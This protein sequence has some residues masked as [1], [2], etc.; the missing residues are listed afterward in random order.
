M[1]E[2]QMEAADKFALARDLKALGYTPLYAKEIASKK[3]GLK[4]FS[5]GSV[6]SGKV[7]LHEKI[8]FAK[9]LSGM[10]SAGLPLSRALAVL[11]KQ[12]TNKAF[13]RILSDMLRSVNEGSSLSQGMEKFPKIFSNLFV[14]MVRAGEESGNLANTLLETSGH[15]Q[16]A[17]ELIKKVKGAMVYPAVI[18]SAMFL[19][20]VLMFIY[21]VPTLTK[22]FQDLA[23]E[24]PMSTRIIVFISDTLS[25]HLAIFAALVAVLVFGG[26]G[27]AKLKFIQRGFDRFSLKLPVVGVMVQ[28]VNSA[29]IS[30][31]LGS[32]LNSGVSMTKAISI[33]ADVVQNSLYKETLENARLSVEK[34]VAL[35]VAIKERTDLFPVMVGEMMEVGEET[36]NLSPMLADIAVFYEGEIDTKTKDLS[37]I[38]EPVLMIII[39]AAVGF[40]ALAMIT[41]MYSLV[42]AM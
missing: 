3:Q 28:E 33:S 37:T 12:S 11:E 24:L 25:N 9:N 40:F 26:I 38:V 13:K 1:T 5:F 6:F 19:I 20:G 29:R 41:P 7:S 42:S 14:S 34:G 39:G 21:V 35:S 15:L 2:G 22:T 27:A 36:G 10:I 31:T 16:K 30:R 17:Y 8:M 32:L 18:I 4:G 23:V